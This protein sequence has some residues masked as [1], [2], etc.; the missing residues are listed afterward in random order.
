VKG[1]NMK[2]LEDIRILVI[3]DIMLD[4][5]V[6]G[7][8]NRISP[9]APVQI[10]QVID[11]YSNLGGC[12]NVVKNIRDL[13][14][15]V[16]CVASIGF[17]RASETISQKLN[18]LDIGDYLIEESYIAI[19][20]ERIVANSRKIQMLRIDRE[21][22]QEV[23]PQIIIDQLRNYFSEHSPDIIIVS[24]YAKGMIGAEVMKYL[25]EHPHRIIIDPKPQHIGYYND[26][27]M[28]TPNEKEWHE[29]MLSS[30]CNLDKVKY[31]LETKGKHGMSLKDCNQSWDIPA[32]EVHQV[33]NLSGAGDTVIAIMGVCLSLG[34]NPVQS[35]KIA[36]ACAAY[37]VTKPDTSTVPKEL[38][39]KIIEEKRG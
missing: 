30:Q 5:Y 4:K 35:A 20:K 17:D 24:D 19:V 33:Y 23:D 10:V 11:E 9:E 36:N 39:L 25:K 15:K 8:V 32:E 12:G 22:V 21:I 27:F 28:V 1:K 6:V 13:G 38:F 18:D 37:V 31:I 16:D 26:V 14:A 7:D 3:G 34:L 2:K 29:M